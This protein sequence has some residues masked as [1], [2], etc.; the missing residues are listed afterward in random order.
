MHSRVNSQGSVAVDPERSREHPPP[1]TWAFRLS[2][3]GLLGVSSSMASHAIF[4]HRSAV[5]PGKTLRMKLANCTIEG[6]HSMRGIVVTH[7][8]CASGNGGSSSACSHIRAITF[9]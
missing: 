5:S 4:L 3:I 8:P 7:L 1:F 6:V 2:A 9:T